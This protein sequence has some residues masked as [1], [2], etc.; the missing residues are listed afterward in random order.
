[1]YTEFALFEVSHEL[2]NVDRL[3]S[4]PEIQAMMRATSN[5]IGKRCSAT[6]WR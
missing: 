2:P 6:L 1:M 4:M 3:W 5:I